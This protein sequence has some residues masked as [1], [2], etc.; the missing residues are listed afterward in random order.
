MRKSAAFLWI[1]SQEE[2]LRKQLREKLARGEVVTKRSK[3]AT[4]TGRSAYP[5][6]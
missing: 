1:D 3:R 6:A 5:M 4:T 2:S